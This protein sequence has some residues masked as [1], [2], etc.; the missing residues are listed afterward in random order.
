MDAE[1][2][3]ILLARTIKS[4][5]EDQFAQNLNLWLRALVHQD[6][7]TILTYFRDQTP[8]LLMTDAETSEVHR[9]MESVYLRGAYLLDPFYEL[10]HSGAEAGLY[11]ISEIAPDQFNRNRYFNDY[12]R[13]TTLIDEIAF[14]VWPSPEIGVHVC[15]GRDERS[16]QKF[17]SRERLAAKQ[18]SPIVE[19][20][21]CANWAKLRFGSDDCKER[22]VDRMIR[23]IAETQD[24]NLTNRQAEVALLVLQ[25]HSSTS[26]GLRLGISP[27]TVKVFRKQLYKRCEVSSQAELFGLML[28]I[29]SSQNEPFTL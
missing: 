15:L 8:R 3:E 14:V 24:I 23:L 17:S 27:Q 9:N 28:P 16:G 18:V 21:V 13:R 7:T 11:R 4:L 10:H 2:S 12:Y 6:N 20:L 1:E 19:A 26:I 25:G 29:L 22:V 5:N